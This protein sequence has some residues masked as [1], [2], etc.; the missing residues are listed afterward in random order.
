MAAT[1]A[2]EQE[3]TWV[4]L[5]PHAAISEQEQKRGQPVDM[6]QICPLVGAG[7]VVARVPVA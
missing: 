2:A 7:Q 3:V 1:S 6:Q 5:A 4:W